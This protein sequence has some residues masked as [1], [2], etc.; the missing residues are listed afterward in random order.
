MRS[1]LLAALVGALSAT[2][3]AIA[4]TGAGA[5]EPAGEKL[6]CKKNR[7]R[8]ATGSN[9]RVSPRD[10]RTAAEWARLKKDAEDTMRRLDET[11]MQRIE[12]TDRLGGGPIA[13]GPG[14]N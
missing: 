11:S 14:N 5:A 8:T 2:G 10:C 7:D 1:I 4:A 9:M 6:I 12:R 3:P 13:P